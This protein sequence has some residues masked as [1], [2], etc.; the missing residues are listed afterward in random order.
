MSEDQILLEESTGRTWF[1]KSRAA[2]SLVRP[3]RSI[4]LRQHSSTRRLR[5]KS[6]RNARSWVVSQCQSLFFHILIGF[7]LGFSFN[8][9]RPIIS[10]RVCFV[11]H[12]TTYH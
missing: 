4:C 1:F 12:V 8:F 2:V 9:R 7:S 11:V 3:I 5:V 6:V 10:L